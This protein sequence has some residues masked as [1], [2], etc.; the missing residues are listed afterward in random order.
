[1]HIQI[2][3]DDSQETIL[4]QRITLG[5]ALEYIAEMMIKAMS[6]RRNITEVH[7]TNANNK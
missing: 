3:Y 4:M 2:K 7:I 5:E 6:V 1:M